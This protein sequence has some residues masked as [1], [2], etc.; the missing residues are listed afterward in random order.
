MKPSILVV[1]LFLACTA[2]ASLAPAAAADLP[3]SKDPPF[4]KRYAGSEIIAYQTKSYEEYRMVTATSRGWEV[5][6]KTEGAITRLVYRVPEGHTGLELMRNYEHALAEAGFALTY[7]FV[8]PDNY[9]VK[10]FVGGFYGQVGRSDGGPFWLYSA[11]AYYATAKATKDGQ[12]LTVAVL[13]GESAGGKWG[14]NPKDAVIKAGDVLVAVDMVAAKAVE[15]KMV[16]VKA[17]D[18]ADALATTGTVDLY[19]IYF[20]VDKSDVKPESD[21]TL[22]VVASL[23]KIDRSLKLEISGHTDSTG[24]KEH[25]LK[26]SQDRA[27]AV[28]DALV[29]KYSIDPAR[30]QAQGYGDSKPVAGNDTEDGRAKNRRVEL[31]KL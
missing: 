13:V 18:I 19:G 7:E 6:A 3:G 11:A 26:L 4:L 14:N 24:D 10:G 15:I 1:G 2:T 9:W 30:L 27:T 22:D 28:V 20:D 23:L 17:A 12:D 16:E 25:N 5:P 31:K 8:Q 29:K 21:K